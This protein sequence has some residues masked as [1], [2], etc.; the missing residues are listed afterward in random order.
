MN[1]STDY[2]LQRSVP[3]YILERSPEY[4][5][6]A[7]ESLKRQGAETV[8]REIYRLNHPTVVETHIEEWEDFSTMS[9]IYK[10]HYRLTAV[11]FRNVTW[12]EMPAFTFVNH[13]GK[14]EWKCR[15]CSTINSIDATY[16]GELHSRAVGCGSP[17]EKTRQEMYA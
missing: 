12:Y 3:I 5:E 14:M 17:R 10:L 13:Q 1:P 7:I 8:F 16:C 11:Q 4:A 9:R 2:A 6:H 15:A